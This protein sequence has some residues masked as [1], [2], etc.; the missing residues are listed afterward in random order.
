MA[1]N[2][3]DII[4]RE[5][6][7]EI[8]KRFEG[9][10]SQFNAE[11]VAIQSRADALF[12]EWESEG[13]RRMDTLF[14]SIPVKAVITEDGD[15]DPVGW[16]K[17]QAKS[18]A[19]RTLVQGLLAVVLVAAGNAVTQ[20]IAKGSLDIFSWEDWKVVGALAGSA[21]LA[22][23]IAYLQNTFGIKPPKVQ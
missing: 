8:S 3:I 21:S 14:A 2:A 10:V 18:R 22:A 20:A 9:A 1:D 19:L 6:T 15:F 11:V 12:T 4:T 5:V 13:Q 23:L 7:A 16:I 17:A